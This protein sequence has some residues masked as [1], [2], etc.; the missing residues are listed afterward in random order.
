RVIFYN[1]AGRDIVE[2]RD[3]LSL[4]RD[5]LAAARPS[6]SAALRRTVTSACGHGTD[7]ERQGGSLQIA[8][9]SGRRAYAV[10][11][12]PLRLPASALAAR[13]PSAIV[14]CSDPDRA[15]TGVE[16]V[17]R[18]LYGL[19][20]AEARVTALLLSGCTI[21]EASEQLGVSLNTGRTHLKRILGKVDVR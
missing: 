17:L 15:A 20:V 1:R 4:L 19:T 18:E 5:G 13:T 14:F 7:P 16:G 12:C 21:E 2:R 11:V 9:P 8:R 10:L 6:D 3:G